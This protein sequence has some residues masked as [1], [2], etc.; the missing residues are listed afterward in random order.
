MGS[1]DDPLGDKIDE[2]SER[3]FDRYPRMKTGPWQIWGRMCRVSERFVAEAGKSLEPCELTYKEFQTIAALVLHKEP[4]RPKKIAAFSM[5]TSG[6]MTAILTRLEAKGLITR[7]P[8]TND[9]REVI[10]EI[11]SR[12]NEMF[13]R[14]LAMENKVEHSMLDALDQDERTQLIHLLRKMTLHMGL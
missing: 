7:T 5:L 9:K 4:M 11:T 6:G 14:A 10:V 1:D 8:S 13:Q 12:G 3:W 2:L